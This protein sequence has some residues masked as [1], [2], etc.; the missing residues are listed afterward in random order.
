MALITCK[1]CEKQISDS[2]EACP[3]CGY[4]EKANEN[5]LEHVPHKGMG[6]GSLIMAVL[7]VIIF[8]FI[9]IAGLGSLGHNQPVTDSANHYQSPDEQRKTLLEQRDK[10]AESCKNGHAS[11][12]QQEMAL[13]NLLNA[14]GINTSP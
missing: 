7:G 5:A 10:F 1:E 14:G 9:L 13:T 11:D 6:C 2:A 8:F 3:N 12:C 4:K